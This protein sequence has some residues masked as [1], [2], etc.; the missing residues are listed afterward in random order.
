MTGLR[1]KRASFTIR[2]KVFDRCDD[3]GRPLYR[4][5]LEVVSGEVFTWLGNKWGIYRKEH[6]ADRRR[7]NDY[8]MVDLATGSSILI[9]SRKIAILE[10]LSVSSTQYEV[11][12]YLQDKARQKKVEEFE[13]LKGATYAK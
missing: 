9:D 7:K 2:T 5:A 3:R 12:R 13:K 1:L 10:F 8:V 11:K 6:T 4:P